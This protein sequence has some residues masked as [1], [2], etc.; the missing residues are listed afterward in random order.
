MLHQL[1]QFLPGNLLRRSETKDGLLARFPSIHN[2]LAFINPGSLA[3]LKF[4]G[5]LMANR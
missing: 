3:L 4:H 1:E 2:I 5:I